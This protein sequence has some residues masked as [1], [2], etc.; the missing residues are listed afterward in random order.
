MELVLSALHCVAAVEIPPAPE[1]TDVVKKH[2]HV[3]FDMICPESQ[4]TC[5]AQLTSEKNINKG[6]DTGGIVQK[7]PNDTDFL[8]LCFF[9]NF[10]LKYF[11]SKSRCNTERT[12]SIPSH[13]SFVT[14]FRDLYVAHIYLQIQIDYNMEHPLGSRCL[15]IHK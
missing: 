6:I 11:F 4:L 10:F 3:V 13:Q 14:T 5:D 7:G 9:L 8:V 2:W 1:A 15:P 12:K